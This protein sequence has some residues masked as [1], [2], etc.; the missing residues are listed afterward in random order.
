MIIYLD[1]NFNDFKI[2]CLG[3]EQ[4]YL[5]LILFK[6]SVH[7]SH[8]QVFLCVIVFFSSIFFFLSQVYSFSGSLDLAQMFYF[9]FLG[10]LFGYS[11]H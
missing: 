11:R 3:D 5:I 7:N 9:R 2:K 10:D 8:K 1:L 4:L 6:F